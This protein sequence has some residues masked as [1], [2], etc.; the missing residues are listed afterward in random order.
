MVIDSLNDNCCMLLVKPGSSMHH[1]NYCKHAS[2]MTEAVGILCHVAWIK[3]LDAPL[4]LIFKHQSLY[5]HA[6]YLTDNYVLLSKKNE[7]I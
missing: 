5:A 6:K 7:Y 2:Q 4:K 1:E 3:L